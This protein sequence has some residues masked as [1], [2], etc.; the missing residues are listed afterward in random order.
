MKKLP[1]VN[2]VSSSC[3]WIENP[4]HIATTNCDEYEAGARAHTQAKGLEACPNY[5]RPEQ[6]QDWFIGY[7]DTR[8]RTKLA[9]IFRKYR[10]FYP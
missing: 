8:T 10:I 2:R 3:P 5:S 4:G 1:P 9:H 7:L 6:R